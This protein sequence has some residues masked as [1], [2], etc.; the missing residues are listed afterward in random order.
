MDYSEF[1][2][3][4]DNLYAPLQNGGVKEARSLAVAAG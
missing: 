3:A 2:A 1:T 4:E